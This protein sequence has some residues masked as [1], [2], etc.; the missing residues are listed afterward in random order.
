MA[1]AVLLT[2]IGIIFIKHSILNFLMINRALSVQVFLLMGYLIRKHEDRID[3]IKTRFVLCGIALYCA[4][5]YISTILYP[6]A[7]IDV[8]TG[9]YYNYF[10]SFA[11]IIIG[12]FSLFA[13]AKR[14]PFKNVIL[15]FIGQNTLIYYIW[16]NYPISLFN[17]LSS[18]LGVSIHNVYLNAFARTVFVCCVCAVASILINRF[19]PEIVGKKRRKVMC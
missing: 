8:H 3:K 2:V 4:I 19:I 13:I 7:N 12:C 10:I 15:V 11:M 1:I 18:R 14:I 5:G 9:I 6:G 17:F 16:G